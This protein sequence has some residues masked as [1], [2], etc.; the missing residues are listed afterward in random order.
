MRETS[1]DLRR[2][3][4]LLD[5]SYRAAGEHLRSVVTP[6][7]R[8][9]AETLADRL[10]GVRVLSLATVTAGGRPLVAP[11]DGLLFRGSFWFGS[12]A[13]SVRMRHLTVRPWV[14]ATY[15]EG[16]RF[17]VIVHGRAV[18]ADLG[19]PAHRGFRDLCLEVY[20]DSWEEWGAGAAY[21]SIEADRFFA[22]A[23][24]DGTEQSG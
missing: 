6:E 18:M 2:L 23:F 5:A 11:V 24:E 3:D 17:G 9:T 8:V 21:A 4:T 16:E 22:F 12:S 19:D 7:R 1:E 14:S 13:S 20:G 10:T 15:V